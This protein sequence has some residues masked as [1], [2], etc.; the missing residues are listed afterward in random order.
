MVTEW[1]SGSWGGGGMDFMGFLQVRKIILV[2][3]V[4]GDNELKSLLGPYNFWACGTCE[5]SY[6]KCVV[7]PICTL[8]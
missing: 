2:G 3:R 4:T 8:V 6:H 5:I 7:A 1:M